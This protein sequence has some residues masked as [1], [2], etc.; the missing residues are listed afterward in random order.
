MTARLAAV[1]RGRPEWAPPGIDMAAWAQAMAEDV[2]E[3]V[4][5]MPYVES[6]GTHDTADHRGLLQQLGQRGADEALIVAGDAPDLPALLLAKVLRGLRSTGVAA[7]P[8]AN[9]GLV[10][11]ACRIPMPGWLAAVDLDL[12]TADALTRLAG[13]APTRR[14]LSVGPGWQRLRGPGDL[15]HLDP[16]LEGW[17]RTRLLLLRGTAR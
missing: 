10:A 7:C 6:A 17:D 3:V 8:A 16:N 1:V 11:L 4:D 15:A 9:G 12:D 13:A 5:D 14:E 2:A